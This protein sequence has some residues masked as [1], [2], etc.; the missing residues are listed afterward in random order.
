MLA[1]KNRLTREAFNLHFSKGKRIHGTYVQ[2][3]IS[4][5]AVAHGSVVVGKKVY[6]RAVDRN[7]LRRRIYSL[8]RTHFKTNTSVCIVITKPAI[9]N[10]P[11][12]EV[13]VE[14]LKLL[15]G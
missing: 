15:A 14:L 5:S 10:V 6:T 12:T 1:K 9:K 3:I 7:R 4:P 11:F 13:K 2:L 8:L